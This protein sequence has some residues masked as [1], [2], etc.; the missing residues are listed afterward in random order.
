MSHYYPYELA[1]EMDKSAVGLIEAFDVQGL[2]RELHGEIRGL[3]SGPDPYSMMVSEKLG[4]KRSKVLD[5]MNSGDV[6]ET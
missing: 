2:A 3:W 4:A 1:V 6:P 5:Y